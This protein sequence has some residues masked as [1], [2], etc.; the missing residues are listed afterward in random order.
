MLVLVETRK[1]SGGRH[2][3]RMKGSLRVIITLK[4]EHKVEGIERCLSSESEIGRA[5]V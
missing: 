4:P 3:E 1:G 5:H 2:A